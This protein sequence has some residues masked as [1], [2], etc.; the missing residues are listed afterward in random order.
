MTMKI[1]ARAFIVFFTAFAVSYA[2]AKKKEGIQSKGCT[3]NVEDGFFGELDGVVA[4]LYLE[5]EGLGKKC[6]DFQ[7]DNVNPSPGGIYM[8]KFPLPPVNTESC[9][10]KFGAFYLQFYSPFMGF[11]IGGGVAC[12][13]ICAL[14]MDAIASECVYSEELVG[15]PVCAKIVN[16]GSDGTGIAV[17]MNDAQI[18]GGVN[19]FYCCSYGLV[20][21]NDWRVGEI[22]DRPVEFSAIKAEAAGGHLPP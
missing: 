8:E 5:A 11:N 20:V 1:T 4:D 9:N 6:S 7:E 18:Q 22:L 12:C 13:P 15:P 14:D 3:L 21:V 17:V 2:S 19:E 16:D 10:V